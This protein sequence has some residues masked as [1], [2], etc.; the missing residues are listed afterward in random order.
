MKSLPDGLQ[1]H[2]D[3]GATTLCW[4]WQLARRDNRVMGF[5]DH[6]LPLSFGGVTY[7]AASGFTATE[8]QSSL[9]LA[10]DNLDVS[11][12]LSSSA[13]TEADISAG[14]YDGARV[15]IW[16]VN[17]AEPSQRVLMR[18][19]HLGEISRGDLYFSAEV[20]GLAARLQQKQGRLYQAHCDADLADARC[21]VDLDAGDYR[22]SVSVIAQ[23][24]PQSVTVDGL[25]GY[26]AGWFTRGVMTFEDGANRGLSYPIQLHQITSGIVILSTWSSFVFEVE[27]GAALS[28]VVGC[29][30]RFATCVEKFSNG[31]NFRG[32]PHM[33]GNDYL[34]NYPNS[35]DDGLSG[36][37]RYEQY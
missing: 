18:A 3:S 23:N 1:E 20:R 35:G 21:G 37:Y 12:A 4:C 25:A 22:A 8:I 10:V 6:D 26:A 11:G 27:A 17:W 33:P 28:L 24:G 34:T 2:L 15:E 14:V 31:A 7:E 19:G 32:C 16:R 29:D 36:D 9:G 5:T 13:I 30:K